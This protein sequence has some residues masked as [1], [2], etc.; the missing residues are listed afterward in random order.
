MVVEGDHVL[1]GLIFRRNLTEREE[2]DS[3]SMLDV[4][5]QFSHVDV[6]MDVR[7]WVLSTDGI[8]S[9]ASFFLALTKDNYQIIP[10]GSIWKLKAPP[11]I[12]VFRWLVLRGSI[13]TIDNLRHRNV[14]IVNACPLY[15]RQRKQWIIFS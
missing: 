4:L 12:V 11:I 14:V 1:L 15:T 2:R 6:G 8:F 5:T 7:V 3:F 13:L 10:L 9:V